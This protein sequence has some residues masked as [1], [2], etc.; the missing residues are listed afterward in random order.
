[1]SRILAALVLVSL[2]AGC[3]SD[4]GPRL[5]ERYEPARLDRIRL[6]AP[7]PAAEPHPHPRHH[8]GRPT[9]LR[10]SA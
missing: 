8:P 6:A 7:V 3:A 2:L 1:M 10:L 4:P 9:E 5:L